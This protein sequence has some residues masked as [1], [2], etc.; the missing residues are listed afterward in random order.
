MILNCSGKSVLHSPFSWLVCGV[1]YSHTTPSSPCFP[2]KV[3]M[4]KAGHKCHGEAEGVTNR[5]RKG[6]RHI[7]PT[8]KHRTSKQCDMVW[9]K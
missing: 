1:I 6:H 8:I 2:S 5:L 3:T 4:V 7:G 9:D